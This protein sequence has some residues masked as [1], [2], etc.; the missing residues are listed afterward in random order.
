MSDKIDAANFLEPGWWK[1]PS[2]FTPTGAWKAEDEDFPG[3]Y[4]AQ[5]AGPA[6]PQDVICSGEGCLNYITI[7]GPAPKVK[8]LCR[9]HTAEAPD[10]VRF[11]KHQHDKTLDKE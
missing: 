9:K 8:Y 2:P 4:S 11:Q 1:K 6:Q 7:P 5:Q 10:E 3:D